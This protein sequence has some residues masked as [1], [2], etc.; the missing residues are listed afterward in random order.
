MTALIIEELERLGLVR[1][2]A[3]TD[4]IKVNSNTAVNS[5]A[6]GILPRKKLRPLVSKISD[7]LRFAVFPQFNA[8]RIVS[9]QLKEARITNRK[10]LTWGELRVSSLE[11]ASLEF[12]GDTKD[13]AESV[14]M[15]VIT[16]GIQREPRDFA[17]QAAMVSPARF[18]PY[19]GTQ[20]MNE[21]VSANLNLDTGGLLGLRTLF[22]ISGLSVRQTWL[23]TKE[24]CMTVV[25]SC[26][27]CLA[28]HETSFAA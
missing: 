17:K 18:L 15:E 9:K 25:Q 8:D 1:P 12:L 28:R 13:L 16:I 3:F 19:A 26:Q 10:L 4:Q 6:M 24:H 21:L 20:P 7:C 22:S 23:K 11:K 5:L 14:T 2:E 27:A